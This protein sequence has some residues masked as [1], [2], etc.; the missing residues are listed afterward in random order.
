[1]YDLQGTRKRVSGGKVHILLTAIVPQ[2][3]TL[4]HTSETVCSKYVHF[5]VC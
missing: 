5:V 1:M 2:V 3:Y 4:V